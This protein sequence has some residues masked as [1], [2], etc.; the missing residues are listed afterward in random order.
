MELG[1]MIERF[2]PRNEFQFVASV[3]GKKLGNTLNRQKN[4]RRLD[5]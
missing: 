4:A 3:P 1:S 2:D 5:L